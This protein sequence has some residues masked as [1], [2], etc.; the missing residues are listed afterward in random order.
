MV[1]LEGLDEQQLNWHPPAEGANSVYGIANDVLASAERNLLTFLNKGQ[2]IEP[3]RSE[4]LV[5]TASSTHALLAHYPT[6]R[7]DIQS[8]LLA[9]SPEDL[10]REY[11]HPRFEHLTGRELL[12]FVARHLAEH[13]GQ[14]ELTRDL[15][16]ALLPPR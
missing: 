8:A 12:L 15:A 7:E 1:C 11:S 10:E 6:L 3:P 9:L 4:E 13:L 14:V 2:A 16:K 5:V